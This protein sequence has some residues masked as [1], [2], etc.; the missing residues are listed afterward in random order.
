MASTVAMGSKFGEDVFAKIKE[1]IVSDIAKIQ[2]EQAADATQKAYCD[3]E[4]AET[5]EKVDTNKAKIEKHTTKIEQKSSNSLRVKS[6]VSTLQEE[7]S[8]L[9]KNK[10]EMDNLRQTEKSDYEF[11]EAETAQSLSEIKFALKTL[12]DFYGTY[13]KEHSG[14]SSSDGT[15]QGVIAMLE[16]V[17]AEYA[18]SLAQL[19]AVEDSAVRE[20]DVA[21]KEFETEKVVKDK[22]IK[23]KTKEFKGLDKYAADET[24]DR[25]G[26]QSE[27]DANSD[28][29]SKLQQMCTGKAETYEDRVARREEEMADLKETLDALE[30]ETE[31][32]G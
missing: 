8:K 4:M 9:M 19:T 16:T 1:M 23:Y 22:A 26:V 6:E 5:Q 11:N 10:A 18:K 15:A 3:K 29:L 2:E 13:A 7:L 31:G 17:E 20:Y 27:F 12:R 21:A 28:A 32:E 25:D 30:S 14:F 24:T